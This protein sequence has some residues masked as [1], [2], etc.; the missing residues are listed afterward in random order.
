LGHQPTLLVAGGEVLQHL[1]MQD[2]LATVENVFR[3]HGMSE[4]V[5]PPKL[6]LDLRSMNLEAWHNAMPAYVH[7]LDAAGLKWVGGYALNPSQHG[8]PSIMATIILQEPA[9]GYPLAIM[10]GVQITNIRTGAVTAL[11][12]RLYGRSDARVVAFIGAGVQARTT[13][14]AMTRLFRLEEVR[15]YD[16]RPEAAQA[17]AAAMS[18]RHGVQVRVCETPRTAVTEADLVVTV[19]YADE[20]LVRGEWLAPGVTAISVGSFQEFDDAAVLEADKIVVDSWEQCAHRGELKRFAESGRLGRAHIFAEVGETV[21]RKRPGRESA[22]ERIMVVPMGLGTHDIAL[23]K[24]VYER[25][26][27]SGLGAGFSFL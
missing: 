1:D 15:V 4:V 22:G 25:V 19:T 18:A 3:A 2:V 27:A 20:P 23:A 10:D 5:M 13:L 14:D 12:A 16:R 6:M 21:A 17:Y 24:L 26:K 8:L 11:C 7:P 9:T